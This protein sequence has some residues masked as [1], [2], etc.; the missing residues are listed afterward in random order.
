MYRTQYVT[1][2]SFNGI[3]QPIMGVAD[4]AG[5]AGGTVKCITQ[6]VAT[7][8]SSVGPNAR[9]FDYQG[10]TPSGLKGALTG[11]SAVLKGF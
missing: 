2:Q 6:G 1:I 9:V 3:L 8:A 11:N 10:C 7:L 4:G 5:V